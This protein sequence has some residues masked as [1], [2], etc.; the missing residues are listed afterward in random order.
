M[1]TPRA[2][3]G[4]RSTPSPRRDCSAPPSI[5]RPRSASSAELLAGSDATT[6]FTWVQHQ[7][8]L[9]ILEGSADGLVSGA[10]A[11]L[12]D[13][14]L[15]RM[16]TG[17]ALSAVAFAHVR[18]PGSPNP[19]ATRIPGG[20]RLDGVLDWVTSWDIADV[21]MVMAQG[22]GADADRLVC[23]YLPA[24]AAPDRTPGVTPGP[25]LELLAM[26]GTHTRPV[27]LEGVHVPDERVGAVLDRDGVAGSGRACARQMPARP[28]SAWRAGRSPSC[29]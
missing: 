5:R 28:R 3:A 19:V 27:R 22:S 13:D 10:P 26:S 9:R 21:V 24:G 8:P 14:L 7:T 4:R 2:C 11:G 23:C 6:W 17:R 25:V 29:T 1:R 18:R 15:P 20:W 12:T 16:R